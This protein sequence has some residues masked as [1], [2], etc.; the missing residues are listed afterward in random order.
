MER[1]AHKHLKSHFCQTSSTTTCPCVT[2]AQSARRTLNHTGLQG[3][4]RHGLHFHV[5]VSECERAHVRGL[6]QFSLRRVPQELVGSRFLHSGC[7]GR[8]QGAL[9]HTN[10]GLRLT[11][12]SQRDGTYLVRVHTRRSAIM[13]ITAFL[14]WDFIDGYCGYTRWRLVS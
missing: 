12:S 13:D 5:A 1:I 6:A 7:S 8:L 9:T 10:G 4:V 14:Y 3:R 2:P 11:T